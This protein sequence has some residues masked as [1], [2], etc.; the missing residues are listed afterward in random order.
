MVIKRLI[1]NGYE[2]LPDQ[3]ENSFQIIFD[4]PDECPKCGASMNRVG[5]S[6]PRYF[7]EMDGSDIRTVSI[8]YSRYRCSNKLCKAY[9]FSGLDNPI[10][11]FLPVGARVSDEVKL[12]AVRAKLRNPEIS[13]EKISTDYHIARNTLRD[14]ITELYETTVKKVSIWGG[15]SHIL[16]WPVTHNGHTRCCLFGINNESD[17]QQ[18]GLMEIIAP[19]EI[20]G[21]LFWY[22]R[23]ARRDDPS[24]ITNE[25]IWKIT[26]KICEIIRE[27]FYNLTITVIEEDYDVLKDK[28]IPLFY[29]G[30]EELPKLGS[31]SSQLERWFASLVSEKGYADAG[32]DFLIEHSQ[33]I[34]NSVAFDRNDIATMI[35]TVRTMWDYHI[36]DHE[37][38]LRFA[39]TN[40]LIKDDLKRVGLGRFI[41]E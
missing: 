9:A 17:N 11:A 1:E 41:I 19:N 29:E 15:Y 38:V 4:C 32:F 2:V 3:D 16:V 37:I 40:P 36:S 28:I 25:V 22:G 26:P 14:A 18:M 21:F 30:N 23:T 39:F 34:R 35:D 27:E 31:G 6:Q 10:S 24:R 12:S 5:M 13:L 7:E 20:E 8:R 33:W